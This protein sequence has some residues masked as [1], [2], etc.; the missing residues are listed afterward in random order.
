MKGTPE[1]Q[2][3]QKTPRDATEKN[4]EILRTQLREDGWY[5][6]DWLEDIV[7]FLLPCFFCLIVGTHLATSYPVLATFLLGLGMQQAG[8]LSHDYVHARG[9]GADIVGF[10]IGA[11]LNGFSPSWWSHK[12]NTH[13]VFPNRKEYDADIHNEPILHLWFPEEGQDKWFRQYQHIYYP[14]VYSLLYVSWKVQSLQFVVGSRNWLER[15]GLM[16]HYVWLACLP[17]KVA[18][19][20]VILGGGWCV[21][22]RHEQLFW[23]MFRQSASTP[24]YGLQ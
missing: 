1:S 16:S 24:L 23:L 7:K 3:A 6:R 22:Q 11:S 21:Q 18:L 4:F 17:W 13:H 8:W 14:F 9:Q 20:S 15:F 2:R 12:H 5:K 10:F 19:A